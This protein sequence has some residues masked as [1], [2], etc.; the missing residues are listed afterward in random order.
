MSL[1]AIFDQAL[2]LTG[3]E[4]CALLDRVCAGNTALRRKAEQLLLII[5]SGQVNVFFQES[6][7]FIEVRHAYGD[8]ASPMELER[9]E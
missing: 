4:R 1:D 6:A 5:E 2:D 8:A 7:L 3:V 9:C